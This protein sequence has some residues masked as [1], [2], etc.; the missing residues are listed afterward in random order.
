MN[1]KDLLNKLKNYSKIII[2]GP[3]RTG[4]TYCAYIIAKDLG[5]IHLDEN[6][7]AISSVETVKEKLKTKEKL[8]VQCPELTY[9]IHEISSPKEQPTIVLIMKRNI[10]DIQNS[11][12]RIKWRGFNGIKNRYKRKFKSL[13][14]EEWWDKWKDNQTAE[15]RYYF[16]NNHQYYNMKVEHMY[17]PY[18]I[19]EQTSEFISKEKRKNFEPKQYK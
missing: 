8:V 13:Y 19:L 2:A 18:K 16:Y 9:Q 1:Y 15:L 3:Q 10:K 17:V 5:Y 11:E 14:S 7:I 6:K 4:T 12:K